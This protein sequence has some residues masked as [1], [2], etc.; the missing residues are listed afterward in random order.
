MD[1][2]LQNILESVAGNVI[3]AP[4]LVWFMMQYSNLIKVLLENQKDFISTM[5]EVKDVIKQC[6]RR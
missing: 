5:Q 6:K 2:N 4:I 1:V 3:L